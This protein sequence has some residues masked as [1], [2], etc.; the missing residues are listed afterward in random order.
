M[1]MTSEGLMVRFK[2]AGITQFAITFSSNLNE[3]SM[4]NLRP[5]LAIERDKP[6]ASTQCQHPAPILLS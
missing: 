5:E 3:V 1:S 2:L 4:K 6:D